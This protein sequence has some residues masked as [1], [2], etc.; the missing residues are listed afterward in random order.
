MKPVQLSTGFL[1]VNTCFLKIVM[2]QFIFSY[3]FLFLI[4]TELNAQ[5]QGYKVPSKTY[6]GIIVDKKT[7]QPIAYANV[8]IPGK[9]IGTVSNEDG[10]F[11]LEVSDIEDILKISCIGYYDYESLL[12]DFHNRE[13]DTIYLKKSV[14]DLE[15]IIIKPKNLKT[16]V[17]GVKTKSQAISAGFIGNAFGGEVGI[18]MKNKHKAYLQKLYLNLTS[19]YDTLFYRINI[20]KKDES[21]EFVNV[22]TKPIYFEQPGNVSTRPLIIDLVPYNL[23]I[24]GKFLVTMEFVKDLGEG[25]LYFSAAFFRKTYYR[26]TSQSKWGTIPIGVSISVEALVEK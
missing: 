9:N 1:V 13:I 3:F 18:L 10:F 22:L 25:S 8:G 5:H 14:V 4:C 2:K 7:K 23:Q 12:K 6:S 24:E 21:G 26:E 11:S 15:E 17:F 16:K 19:T 20:Y